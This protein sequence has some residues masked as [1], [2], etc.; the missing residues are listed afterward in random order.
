MKIRKKHLVTGVL[1]AALLPVSLALASGDSSQSLRNYDIFRMVAEDLDVAR[2]TNAVMDEIKMNA[3]SLNEKLKMTSESNRL[4]EEQ[5][6]LVDEFNV[7]L[8]MQP[9]M[10]DESNVILDDV[11]SETLRS[12]DLTYELYPIMDAVDAE[13]RESL[14]LAEQLVAAMDSAVNTAAFINRQLDAAL[15]YTIR[16]GRQSK[17]MSAFMASNPTDLASLLAYVPAP[18]AARKAP[19]GGATAGPAPA[20]NP[21]SMVEA[22]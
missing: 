4:M 7:Q 21:N 6:A 9:A 22:L 13:M 20:V 19:G 3:A 2:E 15:A 8:D 18:A 5:I 14:D 17:K 1:V 10:M 11:Y 12:L 16:I